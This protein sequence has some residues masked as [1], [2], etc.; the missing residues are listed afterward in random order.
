MKNFAG[1]GKCFLEN[2]GFVRRDN[3]FFTVNGK[4][5]APDTTYSRS[6]V[7]RTRLRTY[8]T[9]K[10]RVKDVLFNLALALKNRKGGA[11]MRAM[12]TH[13]RI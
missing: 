13:T 12:T 5:A 4:V 2:V 11:P 8:H 6:A 1:N 7:A 9:H 10:R 3:R